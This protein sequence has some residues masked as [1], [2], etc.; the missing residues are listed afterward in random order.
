[1]GVQVCSGDG[2]LDRVRDGLGDGGRVA[3]EVHGGRVDI[4]VDV[5][6][7]L[8]VRYTDEVFVAGFSV[9]LVWVFVVVL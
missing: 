8:A 1:M 7:L 4:E 2:S 3:V 6:V 5:T 9:V